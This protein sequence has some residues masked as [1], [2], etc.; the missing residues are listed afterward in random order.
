M[1]FF[2]AGL[3]DALI[4]MATDMQTQLDDAL[5]TGFFVIA[6]GMMAVTL[7]VLASFRKEDVEKC[8]MTTVRESIWFVRTNAGH[9]DLMERTLFLPVHAHIVGLLGPDGCRLLRGDG[10]LGEGIKLALVGYGPEGLGTCHTDAAPGLRLVLS[11]D[12]RNFQFRSI[13]FMQ[14]KKKSKKR[15]GGYPAQRSF[16][17]APDQAYL[18]TSLVRGV[19][20]GRVKDGCI[21]HEA[22]SRPYEMC[23]VIDFVGVGDEG[24]MMFELARLLSRK[25]SSSG[26][27]VSQGSSFEKYDFIR[28]HLN[29]RAAW[30]RQQRAAAPSKKGWDF[31]FKAQER[32]RQK[33]TCLPLVFV[34]TCLCSSIATA[35]AQANDQ[36]GLPLKGA[37]KKDYLKRRRNFINERLDSLRL[38]VPHTEGSTIPGL[39]VQV[40]EYVKKLQHKLNLKPWE[41]VEGAGL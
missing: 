19:G 37:S 14:G 21:R 12:P 24:A 23:I 2:F 25:R 28:A 5:R 29:G 36:A 3:T 9:A 31:A 15:G 40:I 26:A 16:R 20:G 6:R 13:S 30:I 34:N 35:S 41:D 7:G 8:V 1:V 33:R 11:L 27:R 39:L 22:D 4:A 38:L 10:R 17:I 32:K 18:A